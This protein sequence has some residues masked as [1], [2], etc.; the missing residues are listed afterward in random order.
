MKTKLKLRIIWES[1]LTKALLVIVSV[2][3]LGLA[4]ILPSVLTS[5]GKDSVY[6]Y[7]RDAT[8]GT[9]EAFVKKVLNADEDTWSP[10][11]NVREVRNNDA[12]I[13][14]VKRQKNSVGYVSFGTVAQFDESGNPVMKEH[15]DSNVSFATFEG[16]LPTEENI[17]NSNY[18]AARDFNIFFRLEKDSS[19][20]EITK[21]DFETPNDIDINKINTNSN[22]EDLKAAYLFYNWIIHSQESLNIIETGYTSNGPTGEL[23]AV[24]NHDWTTDLDTIVNDYV[25]EME[26]TKSFNYNIEIVGSTS[27][28]ALMTELANE[29]DDEMTE[30]FGL[31]NDQLKIT[32]STNGSGD[33]FKTSVPGADHP[34]IGMQSRDAKESELESWGYDSA[35]PLTYNH[36]A[37][38]AILIIYNNNNVEL[39]EGQYLNT[40]QSQLYDL[41]TNNDEMTYFGDEG[42][43]RKAVFEI[44]TPAKGGDLDA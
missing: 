9:R 36:F 15:T 43:K 16:V 1:S 25:A 27:A 2:I 44:F 42:T 10:G 5:R 20:Y 18:A 30:M 12:M 11:A 23:P 32:L 29:F 17:M 8:S 6:A 39:E 31:S 24:G 40:T 13:T 38:D 3:L 26:M 4:I 22:A 19:E 34:F 35:D 33:A 28:T 37:K 41:Y 7:N 14:F 21:Y